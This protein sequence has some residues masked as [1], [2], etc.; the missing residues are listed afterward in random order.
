MTD[1]PFAESQPYDSGGH[2]ESPGWDPSHEIVADVPPHD[3]TA[4]MA[5]LGSAL[6]DGQFALSRLVGILKPEHF[7]R[8]DHGAIWELMIHLWDG[9]QGIDPHLVFREAQ[10][11]GLFGKVKPEYLADLVGCVSTPAHAQHYGHIVREMADLRAIIHAATKA[12]QAAFA[13]S[14]TRDAMAPLEEAVREIGDMTHGSVVTRAKDGI[15]S[16]LD[17]AKEEGTLGPDSG[18]ILPWRICPRFDKG[19][20]LVRA[21]DFPILAARPGVGKTTFALQWAKVTAQSSG[22]PVVYISLETPAK[23]LWLKVACNQAGVPEPKGQ[24]LTDD[25]EARL[26][27]AMMELDQQCPLHIVDSPPEDLMGLK[28]LMARLNET[29]KPVAF[30][31]DYLGL[32]EVPYTKDEYQAMS[33]ASRQLRVW[34][35]NN[36][37]AVMCLHQLN[38]AMAKEKRPPSMHDLRGSGQIEQDATHIVFL[39]EEKVE[40]QVR[41]CTAILAKA[42]RGG[43]PAVQQLRMLADISR[44]TQRA[45][46]PPREDPA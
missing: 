10:A 14:K 32:I 33:K 41:D 29:L 40:D 37:V 38:R 9:K 27:T 5:V 18:E 17:S 28:G 4:E 2:F 43:A 44:F 12:Q 31:I 39:H 19:G 3:L 22:R 42:R 46:E 13:K 23:D 11:R 15:Q 36:G 21:T 30:V 24:A 7:Y 35:L 8:T 26:G 6:L 20:A 45:W 16:A 1:D 25:M 34:A